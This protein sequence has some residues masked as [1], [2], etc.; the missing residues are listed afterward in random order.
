M[1]TQETKLTAIANAIRTKESSV[2]PI[3][4]N[5][6]ATRILALPSPVPEM[7][8]WTK[9]WSLDPKA[10]LDA[11]TESYP[12]KAIILLDDSFDV[13]PAIT[14]ANCVAV[15]YSDTGFTTDKSAHTWTKSSDITDSGVPYKLRYIIYYFDTDTVEVTTTWINANAIYI[16]FKIKFAST[17]SFFTTTLN[18]YLLAIEIATGFG[19][20]TSTTTLASHFVQFS[21]LEKLDYLGDT[22]AV[23]NLLYFCQYCRSLYD[24]PEE[25][26]TTGTSSVVMSGIFQYCNAL[27]VTPIIRFSGNLPT[28]LQYIFRECYNLERCRLL[29][30]N[31]NITSSDNN[32]F[33]YA[34][35]NCY[36]IRWFDDNSFCDA[37]FEYSGNN[38][39]VLYNNYSLPLEKFFSKNEYTTRATSGLQNLY[40]FN[41]S[42]VFKI[43]SISSGSQICTAFSNT[44]SCFHGILEFRTTGNVTALPT[45]MGAKEI[46]AVS[47]STYTTRTTG[48]SLAGLRN[49][50]KIS[51]YKNETTKALNTIYHSS[52]SA[53]LSS[54]A[55]LEELNVIMDFQSTGTITVSN[56]FIGSSSDTTAR[57]NL[58]TAY[59][60]L[61]SIPSGSIVLSNLIKFSEA[62]WIYLAQNAPTVTGR[63]ITLGAT[64]LAKV[65]AI[66]EPIS[67]LD[68]VTVLRNLGWTVN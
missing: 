41:Y 20:T 1:S 49:C 37:I 14:H 10:I 50:R 19:F 35:N 33:Y 54:S 4:A 63:T 31:Q 68:C 8:H 26:L 66:I 52:A 32:N 48:F 34:F 58:H 3:V 12:G 16:Y 61:P 67:G 45:N 38:S 24:V 43:N 23:S 2:N 44:N 36:K 56:P 5:D 13:S 57:C 59:L 30:P 25:I 17:N 46:L 15:Y 64:L 29:A 40:G 21:R 28:T 7:D 22:S 9:P 65:G 27:K 53:F 55:S 42:G 11:D 47:S 6:F 62:S 51:F 39:N 60:K 18:V